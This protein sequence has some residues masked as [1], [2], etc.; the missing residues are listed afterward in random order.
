MERISTISP[1]LEK[2]SA[3]VS[4][5]GH[6]LSL[7]SDGDFV[8]SH[9]QGFVTKKLLITGA[10]QCLQLLAQSKTSAL[11]VD[12]RS[13]HGTWADLGDWQENIWLPNALQAGL[14]KYVLVAH[15][16]SYSVMAAEPLF[17]KLHSQ[18]EMMIFSELEEAKSWL[19]SGI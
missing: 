2:V 19:K 6:K 17:S 3:G 8:H 16:G 12:H 18:L 10:N 15:P 5:N 11:L 14:R 7:S 9:W 4:S 1:E 13:V